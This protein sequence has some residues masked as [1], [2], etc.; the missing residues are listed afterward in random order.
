MYYDKG[1]YGKPNYHKRK[2]KLDIAIL[3]LQGGKSFY[4]LYFDNQVIGESCVGLVVGASY[5]TL[6]IRV[7]FSPPTRRISSPYPFLAHSGFS[8]PLNQKYKF[9][10]ATFA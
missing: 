7:Q 5:S 6:V 10:K 1:I 9:N 4:N 2:S 8:L 3:R